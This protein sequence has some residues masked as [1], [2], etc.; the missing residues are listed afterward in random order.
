MLC[1]P[2]FKTDTTDFTTKYSFEPNLIWFCTLHFL[3]SW[4]V[5]F[6]VNKSR[7]FL[8]W[9]LN[10]CFFLCRK[11]IHTWQFKLFFLADQTE[12]SHL[13]ICIHSFMNCHFVFIQSLLT[14]KHLITDVSIVRFFPWWIISIYLLS[15]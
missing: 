10:R 9:T 13:K 3:P 7:K 2:D 11:L 1:Y 5:S 6:L 14:L 8:Y 4:T 15:Y 12:L